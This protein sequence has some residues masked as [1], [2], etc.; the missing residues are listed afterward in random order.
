MNFTSVSIN[1]PLP[2]QDPIQGSALNLV[3]MSLESPLLCDSFSVFSL[4]SWTWKFR[5]IVEAPQVGLVWCFLIIRLG[6]WAI[7]KNPGE[8]KSPSPCFM[9]RDAYQ[10]VST[11]GM[12]T[13]IVW[14][15]WCLRVSL[16]SSYYF[17]PLHTHFFKSE[18]PSPAHTQK[19]G[20]K[21]H[22]LEKKNPHV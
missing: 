12:L 4:F 5:Y 10:H 1:V 7:G 13:V 18:S 3:I 11:P 16:P 9:L 6:L 8:I 20:C 19:E 21:F 22:P 14:L 17:S 15:R 2:S